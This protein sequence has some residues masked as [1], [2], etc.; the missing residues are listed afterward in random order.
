MSRLPLTSV[1]APLPDFSLGKLGYFYS[2]LAAAD[3]EPLHTIDDF[4]NPTR[5]LPHLAFEPSR[6]LELAIRATPADGVAAL[7]D[8][9]A[10]QWSFVADAPIPSSNC[11]ERC[12]TRWRCRRTPASASAPSACCRPGRARH[13]WRRRPS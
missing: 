5:T 12:L 11:F 7:A 6:L 4:F 2:V 13:C 8:V 1:E 3:D 10:R 9:I